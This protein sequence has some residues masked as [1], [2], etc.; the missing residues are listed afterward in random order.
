MAKNCFLLFGEEVFLKD[1]F[2]E[3]TKNQV[4]GES[5]PYMNYIKLEGK[6]ITFEKI[7]ATCETYPMFV[8]KKLVH[9]KNSQLFAA[10]RKEETE[11]LLKWITTVPNYVVLV[12]DES[13][14]DKRL[15]LFKKMKSTHECTEFNYLKEAELVKR[16][17]EVSAANN[18]RIKDDALYYFVSSM[19]KDLTRLLVEFQKL[20]TYTNEV[21]VSKINEVCTFSTEKK[22]FDMTKAVASKN[23]ELALRIYSE[24]I[25]RKESPFGVLAL[26]GMEYRKILSVKF[27]TSKKISPKDIASRSS[28]PTFVLRDTQ[29]IADTFT[30]AQ[31]EEILELCLETDWNI[32]TGIMPAEIAV[33]MLILNCIHISA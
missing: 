1:Q 10:G 33:E 3:Q 16:L 20:I 12:F 24:L 32:K 22:V 21:T 23:A 7:A 11:K 4:V 9:V 6:D 26:I 31:L 13:S 29:S 14:V 17:R 28:V 25:Q 2:I 27:L 8:E 30:Y 5:D 15:Q 18:V 19:P